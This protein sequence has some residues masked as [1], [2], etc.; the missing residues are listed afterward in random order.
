MTNEGVRLVDSMDSGRIV[1]PISEHGKLTTCRIYWQ[2][3]KS[4]SLVYGG[5]AEIP[6]SLFLPTLDNARIGFT[7]S[8]S[9]S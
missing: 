4:K 8:Y 5:K 2:T 9:G 6:S 7:E 3:G 1:V